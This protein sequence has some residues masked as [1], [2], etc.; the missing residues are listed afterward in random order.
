M[1][2]LG[3]PL[4]LIDHEK[5]ARPFG[6]FEFQPDLLECDL[7]GA[8]TSLG[9]DQNRCRQN[10]VSDSQLVYSVYISAA[11]FAHCHNFISSMNASTCAIASPPFG[12]L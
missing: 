5:L 9:S 3:R 12:H 1:A 8:K 7:W 2:I 4:H 11:L 10:A 6:R